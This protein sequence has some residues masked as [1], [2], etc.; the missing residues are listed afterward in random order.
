MSIFS[1]KSR[2]RLPL[3]LYVYHDRVNGVF[4]LHGISVREFCGWFRP[5]VEN[6]LLLRGETC[7]G[8]LCGARFE[9]A[10]GAAAVAEF[11]GQNID[12]GDFCFVDYANA[13]AA[14]TLQPQE[15][16][17]LLYLGH[18]FRP[19]GSPYFAA[20]GNRFAY[21]SHDDP[22]FC[23]LYCAKTESVFDVI[24]AKLVDTLRAALKTDLTCEPD[25]SSQLARYASDGF[26]V[27][28]QKITDGAREVYLDVYGVGGGLD[29]DLLYNREGEYIKP[30]NLAGR[31]RFVKI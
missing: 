19:L 11:A 10:R 27:D 5:A 3:K 1:R 29:P 28:F 8:E 2:G 17:E 20:L 14:D 21:L 15:V 26:C 7:V 24:A 22:Y 25:L 6:V 13:D 12:C 23:R 16:A 31:V 30:E 18:M 4:L 9:V